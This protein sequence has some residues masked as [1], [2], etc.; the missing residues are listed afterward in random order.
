MYMHYVTEESEEL[1]GVKVFL[2]EV[3]SRM[4][5]QY[6]TVIR[7]ISSAHELSPLRTDPTY[8]HPFIAPHATGKE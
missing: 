3:L 8:E 7:R 2:N 1:R 6:H 4:S 5:S